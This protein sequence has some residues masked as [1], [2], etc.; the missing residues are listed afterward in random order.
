MRTMRLVGVVGALTATLV[1]AASALAGN[2]NSGSALACKKGG[3]KAQ[4]T[5]TGL[6]FKNQGACVSYFVRSS[7]PAGSD[8]STTSTPAGSGNSAAA[9]SCKKGGWATLE[10]ADATTFKNQG[11]CVS[12]VVQGGV[13]KPRP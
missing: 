13:T 6:S 10:R 9:K 2:G 7:D 4:V 8:D 1:L 5:G 3:W 11:G 12:Y